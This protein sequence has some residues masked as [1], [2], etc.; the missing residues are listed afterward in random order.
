MQQMLEFR[1][2][3]TDCQLLDIGFRGPLFTWANNRDPPEFVQETLDRALANVEWTL[4]FG[5]RTAI[6]LPTTSSDHLAF[7]VD[8]HCKVLASRF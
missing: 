4:C 5:T 8:T 6:N 3:I 1:E 7:L 2:A